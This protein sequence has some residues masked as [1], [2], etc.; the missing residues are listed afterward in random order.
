MDT[1][2]LILGAAAG[3]TLAGAVWLAMLVW[4]P[5]GRGDSRPERRRSQ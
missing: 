3:L 5:R 1:N 4:P 2:A